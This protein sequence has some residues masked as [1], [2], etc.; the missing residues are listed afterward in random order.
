MEIHCTAKKI[1]HI[2]KVLKCKLDL[3]QKMGMIKHTICIK[4]KSENSS[5]FMQI[6]I[7]L[8][9]T[10]SL[11]LGPYLSGIEKLIHFVE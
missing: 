4:R 6:F 7:Q 5:Q 2:L 8:A 1:K 11:E 3:K 10:F 9:E